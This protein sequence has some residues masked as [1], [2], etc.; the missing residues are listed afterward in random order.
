[1][2]AHDEILVSAWRL[3][4]GQCGRI[5]EGF[6]QLVRKD[7]KVACVELGDWRVPAVARIA[8]WTPELALRELVMRNS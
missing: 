5:E 6:N 2:P 8:R 4:Y 1:M 7:C 3:G